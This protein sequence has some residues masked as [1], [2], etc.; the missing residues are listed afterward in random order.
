MGRREKERGKVW[1]DRRGE[2][3]KERRKRGEEKKETIT[4]V[5][6]LIIILVNTAH[7]SILVSLNGRLGSQFLAPLCCQSS[8]ALI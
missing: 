4:V 2:G 7:F 8:Q 6:F 1:E 3:E 5:V